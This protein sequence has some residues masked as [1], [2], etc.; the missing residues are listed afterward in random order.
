MLR[1]DDQL[2]IAAN[3]T[4][5]NVFDTNGNRIRTVPKEYRVGRITLFL[6]GSAAG[7]EASF[8]AG[9]QNPMENSRVN[10]QNRI[11]VVP[12]DMVLTDVFVEGG[13]QLQLQ[14]ANTTAGAL[15]VFYRVEIEDYTT[16]AAALGWI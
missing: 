11:P 5:N 1:V 13:E 4:D 12:D 14:V 10:A 2:S 8:F 9:S 7:L 3:T 6:T 16:Q 15:T